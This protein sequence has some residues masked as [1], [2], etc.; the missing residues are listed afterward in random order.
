MIIYIH[1]NKFNIGVQHD[2]IYAQYVSYFPNTSIAVS[3]ASLKSII[4]KIPG[5]TYNNSNKYINT[6][7]KWSFQK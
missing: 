4:F 7:L 1:N 3:V 6:R 5:S 2:I